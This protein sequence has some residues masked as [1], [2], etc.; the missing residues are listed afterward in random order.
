MKLYF[1]TRA[2]LSFCFFCLLFL[3]RTIC[4]VKPFRAYWDKKTPPEAENRQEGQRRRERR[5]SGRR[6]AVL[7]PSKTPAKT[8]TTP[9]ARIHSFF[10]RPSSASTEGSRADSNLFLS[11]L[12]ETQTKTN[13][14]VIIVTKKPTKFLIKCEAKSQG[15][16]AMDPAKVLMGV[17][18]LCT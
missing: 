6:P 5:A 15:C 1:C 2:S 4:G 8:A 7:L 17:F 14:F 3:L 9:Q 18:F 12:S 10:R 16:S 13:S 11:R